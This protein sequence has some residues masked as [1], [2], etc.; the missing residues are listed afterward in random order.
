MS[1][2]LFTS[3]KIYLNQ[4]QVARDLDSAGPYRAFATLTFNEF[5]NE[6]AAW[7]IASKHWRKVERELL[8]R[9]WIEKEIP[10]MTGLV[11]LEHAAVA[12]N[13]KNPLASCHFHYLIHDHPKLSRDDNSAVRELSQ[14]FVVAA[15][16]L[17]HKNRRSQVTSKNGTDVQLVTNQWRLCQYVSKEA[18][19]TPWF[20][21]SRRI[22]FL[23]RDG[24]V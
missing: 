8:G 19:R 15:R 11:V 4:F 22:R 9:N 6:R 16:Q 18:T 3:N 24:A 20:W 23:C 2:K 17:T 12:K 13:I 10:Q 14:A 1:I 5:I 21:N 7:S